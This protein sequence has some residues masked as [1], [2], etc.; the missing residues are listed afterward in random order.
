MTKK[1]ILETLD[2]V[3]CLVRALCIQ[4]QILMCDLRLLQLKSQRFFLNRKIDVAYAKL[5]GNTAEVFRLQLFRLMM[6]LFKA[7]NFV[8]VAIWASLFLCRITGYDIYTMHGELLECTY[9]TFV[10]LV[11]SIPAILTTSECESLIKKNGLWL[12]SAVY[13]FAYTAGL[14]LI[15]AFLM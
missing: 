3:K 5:T 4:L 9:K 7:E 13:I 15:L 6:V 12:T 1:L 10:F 11:L 14:F 2:D 8:F